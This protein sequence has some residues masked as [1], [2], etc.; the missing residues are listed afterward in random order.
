MCN[1]YIMPELL[2]KHQAST[3]MED[4][5]PIPT[6]PQIR[7]VARDHRATL[8]EYSIIHGEV[9]NR[10]LIWVVKPTGNVVFR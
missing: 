2:M 7:Q 9:E 3:E 8:V 5:I 4:R 10:L 1:C 6:L